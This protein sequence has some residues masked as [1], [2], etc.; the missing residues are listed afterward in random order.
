MANIHFESTSRNIGLIIHSI[1]T[2]E[3]CLQKRFN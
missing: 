3:I 1:Y 2:I